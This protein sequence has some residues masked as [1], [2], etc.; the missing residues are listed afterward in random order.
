MLKR[1]AEP[2]PRFH[3]E[4]WVRAAMEVLAKEG[5]AK[6][7]VD[8]LAG[9]LGVTKGSFYHHFKNRDDFV[10][11][12]LAYWSSAFT[13]NVIAEGGTLEGSPEERL[14]QVMR[15]I[16]REGLERYDIAFRSW[17]A[18]EPSVAEGVRKVDQARYRFIRSLFAEMGFEG[19]DLE[20]RV[21]I[22]LV[23]YSAKR[24]VHV[25]KSPEDDEDAIARR[26]AFFTRPC[27]KE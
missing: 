25:P 1:N 16:E 4:A 19:P 9:Q 24:T 8:T 7:R 3:R 6:L 17:A 21:R 27:A 23:F 13:D 18:Q 20:N 15:M 26:H 11:R 5:Q 2:G 14:L 22:W 12:L 10:Q